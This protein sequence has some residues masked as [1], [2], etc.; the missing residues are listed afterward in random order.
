MAEV[1]VHFD[2]MEALEVAKSICASWITSTVLL[3][4]ATN[5]RINY[6]LTSREKKGQT[7]MNG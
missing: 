2:V 3:Q 1:K 5:L 6:R 7:T 4:C